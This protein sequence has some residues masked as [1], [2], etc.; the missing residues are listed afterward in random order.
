MLNFLKRLMKNRITSYERC[1]LFAN[2]N[3]F[4]FENLVT[5]GV[6]SHGMPPKDI[7]SFITIIDEDDIPLDYPY[8]K[9]IGNGKFIRACKHNLKK[10]THP[11][12][13]AIDDEMKISAEN[14]HGG[15]GNFS[16]IY[17]KEDLIQ[18]CFEER[19]R[20]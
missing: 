5:N 6:G 3:L 8:F 18:I 20:Y 12:L 4:G 13:A 1:V 17:K 14:H 11:K 2:S 19:S 10:H 7:R 9:Y 16:P 15:F